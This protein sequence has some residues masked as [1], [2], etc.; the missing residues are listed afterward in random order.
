MNKY[1]FIEWLENHSTLSEYSIGRYANAIDKVSSDLENYG[2][3]SI[4]LFELTETTFIDTILNNAK[5]QKKNNEGNRMYSAALKK[6]KNYI[7]DYHDNNTETQAELL[8]EETVFEKYLKE[9]EANVSEISIEDRPQNKPDHKTVNNKKIWI[10]NPK[11]ASESIA[12]VHYLCEFDN[13]H[14]HFI[15]KFS[16]KNYVEAHHLIPVSFQGQFNSSLDVHANIVSLCLVCHKKIHFGRFA[17][18]K[19]ILDKLFNT[20]KGRLAVSGINV[21]IA[22]LYSYYQD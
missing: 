14:Q 10:R 21:E 7:V 17:D 12:S 13:Q 22:Q 19:E 3:E 1:A 5:F 16:Q 15:S 11:Y 9:K 2:L 6:F 18:K 20:R 8:K 4:N